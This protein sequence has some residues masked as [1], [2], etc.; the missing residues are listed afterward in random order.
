MKNTLT[1]ATRRESWS[2]SGAGGGQAGRDALT[3]NTWLTGAVV[4]G[5]AR[6]SGHPSR[7]GPSRASYPRRTGLNDRGGGA[8]QAGLT[9]LVATP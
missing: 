6:I 9:G 2:G 3:V 5:E 4:A 7:A 1:S 8:V